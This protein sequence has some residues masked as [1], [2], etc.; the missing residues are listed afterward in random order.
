MNAP[1]LLY[2]GV[3]GLCNHFVQF[4]LNRERV[5]EFHFAPLQSSAAARILS[6]HSLSSVDLDTIY[7]VLNCDESAQSVL[8]RSDAILF[9]LEHIGGIWRLIGVLLRLS[10]RRL[11]DWVYCLLARN[12]YHILGR[13]DICLLRTDATRRRFLEL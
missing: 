11:R 7:V 10:P 9:V 2:D 5:P 12:R 13:V 6:R 8:T 3:C 4:I 1:L